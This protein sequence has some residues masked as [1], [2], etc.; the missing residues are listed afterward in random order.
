MRA[1]LVDD[2]GLAL[3]DL[4]RQLHKTGDVEVVGKFRNA[5]EALRL[6]GELQPD[7]VFLD[8]E[9]PEIS[10]LEAAERLQDEHPRIDI[11][12]V[13]AYQDYAIR[14]FELAALDY[15]LKPI[16]AA[17]LARTVERLS[18]RERELP[19]PSPAASDEAK[20][21]IVRCFQRLSVEY[22]KSEPFPWRTARAQELFAYM[23]Y[24]RNQPVRKD[25]LLELLWPNADYKKAYTQ[26]YTTVYQI[27]K[28]IETAGLTIKLTNS[29]S[30]YYL[31]LGSNRY[32][33]QEWEDAR[34]KLPELGPDT[35]AE[36]SAWLDQ[37][38]GDFLSENG[39]PWA[40]NEQRRLRDVWYKHALAVLDAW[41]AAG[42]RVEWL[43]RYG[44]LEEKFPFTEDV[45]F[46][47]MKYYS[48]HG[49]KALAAAKYESLREMLMEEYDIAPSLEIRKWA[50]RELAFV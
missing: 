43:D 12:F 1:I 47:A 24:K 2:E 13:T 23:L 49:D 20:T 29:G 37:Y 8:I 17:R 5:A 25:I 22:G 45:Y 36:H 48:E 7:V 28:S 46:L 34:P 18:Q 33:V 4:E 38:E 50:E 30:D 26:L 10:G 9:M 40:A 3:K 27:R 32:D 15:V 21:A 35:A 39:Y 19:G 31:D 16:N 11:V 42:N 6:V 14:A 44:K 41:K